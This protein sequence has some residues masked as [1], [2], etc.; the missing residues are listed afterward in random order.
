M[1]RAEWPASGHA[2]YCKARVGGDGPREVL[3]FDVGDSE[4]GASE[5]GSC[6]LK[7]PGLHGVQL[8]ISDAHTGLP[9][10]GF[11]LQEW[12]AK[13]QLYVDNL[14]VVRIAVVIAGLAVLGSCCR[15]WS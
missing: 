10:L 4:S 12:A 7:A 1:A 8:V 15:A 9:R 13:R 3:G 11:Q 2:C 6:A 5:P 14:K